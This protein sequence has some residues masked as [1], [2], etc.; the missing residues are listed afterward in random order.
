MENVILS[1]ST[2]EIQRYNNV[3]RSEH[4]TLEEFTQELLREIL[5]KNPAFISD[6]CAMYNKKSMVCRSVS[7]ELVRI[8]ESEKHRV[9]RQCKIHRK[10]LCKRRAGVL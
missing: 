6:T 10:G 4:I 2:D 9:K 7:G 1:L 8:Y 3:L 5:A